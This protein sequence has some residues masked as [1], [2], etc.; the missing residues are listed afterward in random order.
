MRDKS[1]SERRLTVRVTRYWE[2][3]KDEAS[4]PHFGKFN[5]SAIPDIMDFCFV[6]QVRAEGQHPMYTYTEIG[7]EVKKM[8]GQDLRGQVVSSQ[9]R[10]IPAERLIRKFDSCVRTAAP[11]EEDGHFVNHKNQVIHYRSTALPFGDHG[12]VTHILAAL[13][14]QSY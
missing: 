7:S 6:V 5:T 11:V 12:N 14:W 10:F 9:F 1:I 8:F 3:M 13:S 4:L 2:M